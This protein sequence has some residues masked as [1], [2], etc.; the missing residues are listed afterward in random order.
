MW[1]ESYNEVEINP[2]NMGE[3]AQNVYERMN[4]FGIEELPVVEDC[5]YKGLI[6]EEQLLD[7]EPN[8]PWDHSIKE[9]KTVCITENQHV[10][11]AIQLMKTFKVSIIPVVDVNQ[12][13]QSVITKQGLFNYLSEDLMFS[14]R[15]SILVLSIQKRD[16][17]LTEISRLVESEASYILGVSIRNIF[18]RLEVTLKL[19]T[20]DLSKIIATFE[21]LG[22]TVAQSYVE[23]NFESSY[24]DRYDYFLNYLNV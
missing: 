5:M 6:S 22:Y 7:A 23:G 16:Y 18:D 9:L 14:E 12:H 1:S 3:L 19:G 11:E 15:G 21:R 17:S 20:D 13:Y 8:L 10:A 2:V 24:Q 4:L